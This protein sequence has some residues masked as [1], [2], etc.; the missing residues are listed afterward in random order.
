LKWLVKFVRTRNAFVG[1]YQMAHRTMRT[2]TL[3]DLPDRR[4]KKGRPSPS[5]SFR[6]RPLARTRNPSSAMHCCEM[7]SGRAAPYSAANCRGAG[8]GLTRSAASCS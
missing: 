6:A 2:E 3:G 8:G 1:I 7:D 4:S 5:P